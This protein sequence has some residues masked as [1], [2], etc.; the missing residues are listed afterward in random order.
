MD[1]TWTPYAIDAERTAQVLY[2]RDATPLELVLGTAAAGSPGAVDLSPYATAIKQSASE[3]SVTVSWHHE[4][5]GTAQPQPGEIIELKLDG[6]SLWWGIIEAINDYRLERGQ[7]VLTILAR[8]RDAGPFWREAR[9]V[10]DLYPTA[11]PLAF[12]A[13]EV[14]ISLGMTDAELLLPSSSGYTI[15]SN[16]QLADLSGWDMLETLY[17]PGGFAPFVDARG[18]LKVISRDVSRAA[19]VILTE[20]RVVSVNGARN[21]QPLTLVR[22]KWLDPNLTYVSQQDQALANATITA[23]FF[24]LKQEQDVE[25]SRDASQRAG[26]TYMV[27]KQSANSGLVP[28]CDE[29]Y[30]QLTQTTGRITLTTTFWAPLLATADLAFLIYLAANPDIVQTNIVTGTGIT[31]PIGRI[32]QMTAEAALILIMMS[33]GTGMYEIRGTPYDYVHA[34]NTTEAYDCDAPAWLQRDVEIENDFVMSEDAAQAL[35]VRELIYQAK[36]ANSYSVTIVDDPRI[37]PGDIVELHDGT[38]LYVT[39]YSRDLTRGAAATLDIEGFRA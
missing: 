20:E 27:I 25:F 34:R 4:L 35:A 39:S 32:E 13:R 19:D 18:R 6:T 14:A 15:H 36:A 21:R 22:V 3:A 16:T 33:I 12:I 26:S 37:E 2:Y 7:R 24:Q 29:D 9:R 38:R 30:E 31:I 10:T 23:G 1:G 17:L 11:T 8:T 28:V 5:D